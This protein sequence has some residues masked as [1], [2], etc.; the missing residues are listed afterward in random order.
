[1]FGS[2][3]FSSLSSIVWCQVFRLLQWKV[4]FVLICF[5]IKVQDNCTLLHI[6]YILIIHSH[7][8]QH[9]IN[10]RKLGHLFFLP[11]PFYMISRGSLH[12]FKYYCCFRMSLYLLPFP[13]N[14]NIIY[15]P[16]WWIMAYDYKNGFVDKWV[17]CCLSWRL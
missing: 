10:A 2:F 5:L 16:S 1:M 8:F 4:K 13:Q 15:I 17:T 9:R 14:I 3:F 12:G 11:S 6:G 7:H